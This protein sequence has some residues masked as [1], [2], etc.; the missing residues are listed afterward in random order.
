MSERYNKN[1]DSNVGSDIICPSC[2]THFIKNTKAQSFCRTKKGTKCRDKY[3]NTV[4]PS[5]RNNRTRISPASRAW[6]DSQALDDDHPFSSDALG[7]W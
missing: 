2:G 6:S 3:W 7:Q 5:K 4:D 1:K